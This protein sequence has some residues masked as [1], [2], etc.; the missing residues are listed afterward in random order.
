MCKFYESGNL[1]NAMNHREPVIPSGH[2]NS[3]VMIDLLKMLAMNEQEM[4]RVERMYSIGLIQF[5]N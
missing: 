5:R 3:D 4:N 2:L 1:S